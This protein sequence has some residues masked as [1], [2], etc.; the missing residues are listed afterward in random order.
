MNERQWLKLAGKS[1]A[2]WCWYDG[3]T[4]RTACQQISACT[5]V[6]ATDDMPR[7]KTCQRIAK[8]AEGK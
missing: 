6:P 5:T 1:K 4:T 3:L 7:C 8:K 2:H